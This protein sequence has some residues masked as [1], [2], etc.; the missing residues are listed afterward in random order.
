MIQI[1]TWPISNAGHNITGV[2]T[3]LRP[4]P[5]PPQ[6]SPCVLS[7]HS[8]SIHLLLSLPS[9]PSH[10]SYFGLQLEPQK[11]ARCYSPAQTHPFPH[12]SLAHTRL[13]PCLRSRSSPR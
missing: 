5:A 7:Q 1:V 8:I 3:H 2:A 13:T 12:L 6:P 11:R 9:H 4:I 10:P